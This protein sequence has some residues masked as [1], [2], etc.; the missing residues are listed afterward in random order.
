MPV[1]PLS[2]PHAAHETRTVGLP[3]GMLQVGAQMLPEAVNDLSATLDLDLFAGW[4]YV[5]A[6]LGVV[7]LLP[8]RFPVDSHPFF[9]VDDGV[10]DNPLDLHLV[11]PGAITVKYD[12]ASFQM[13]LCNWLP[14]VTYKNAINF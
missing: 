4:K 9:L 2:C 7:R 12:I 10:M 14:N 8:H 6:H 3:A 1:G 11:R 13:L 5:S